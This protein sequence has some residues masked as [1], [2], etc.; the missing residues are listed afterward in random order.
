MR[1][2]VPLLEPNKSS[3]RH[4]NDLHYAIVVPER[5]DGIGTPFANQAGANGIDV[6]SCKRV[7]THTYPVLLSSSGNS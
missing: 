4:E 6:I 5:S 2:C 1:E 7:G 3:S